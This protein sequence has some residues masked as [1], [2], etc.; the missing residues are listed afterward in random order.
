MASLEIVSLRGGVDGREILRGVDLRIGPGE[1]HALMGPNGSGKSTLASVLL[2]RPGYHA[3]AGE[4]RL[5]GVDLFALAPFER[6]RRGLFLVPQYPEEI[7]GVALLDVLEAACPPGVARPSRVELEQEADR[8]GLAR[9]LLDRS[10]NVDLSGGEKKRSE[11][12]QL[13]MLRPQVA[14]LDEIDSGLDIDALAAVA[15]RIADASSSWGMSVLAITHYPR[16]LRYLRPTEVHIFVDGRI[17]ARGDAELASELE[18][19]G[20]APYGAEEA[21][22]PS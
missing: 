3:T 8:I 6:A 20:Y 19:T 2:G 11:T 13:A 5:D 9:P 12:V 22:L 17:V 7:P 14:L 4:A 1:V 16:L 15:R 18:R 21:G 10:V